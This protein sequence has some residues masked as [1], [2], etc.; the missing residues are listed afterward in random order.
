M[1]E[2]T[3][4]KLS[5]PEKQFFIDESKERIG[6]LRISEMVVQTENGVQKY[7]LN[8]DT[9]FDELLA[10]LAESEYYPGE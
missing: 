2:V 1:G 3:G 10:V 4:V 7:F 8:T 5:N 6:E 9:L